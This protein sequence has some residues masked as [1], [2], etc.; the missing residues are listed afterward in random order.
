[1]FLVNQLRLFRKDNNNDFQHWKM[2]K[3]LD[4]P[5]QGDRRHYRMQNFLYDAICC[6]TGVHHLGF[7]IPVPVEEVSVFN[8]NGRQK[9]G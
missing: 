2:E 1:M 3:D 6:R 4:D 7:G 5:L 9:S 8:S